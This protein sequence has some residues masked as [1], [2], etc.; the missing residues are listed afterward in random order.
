[1]IHAA[2]WGSGFEDAAEQGVISAD[3]YLLGFGKRMG[4]SL[5]AAQRV[6]TRRAAM[7]PD[8]AVLALARRLRT[9]RPAGMFTNNL[10]LLQRH[11]GEAFPG[12]PDLFGTRAVF[13]AEL[14]RSKLDPEAFRLATHLECAPDEVL[15]FDDDATYVA[16]ARE[17]GL[18]AHRVGGAAGMRAGLAVHGL[19]CWSP[20]R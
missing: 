6:E 20:H 2:I 1:V 12:V 7:E 16:A 3:D 14:G 11:I 18:S 19:Q 15:Y 17:T 9:V 4:H 8:Q 5:S 10:W 13:S